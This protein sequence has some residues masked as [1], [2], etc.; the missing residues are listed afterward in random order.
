MKSGTRPWPD[1]WL[2]VA[3]AAFFTVIQFYTSLAALAPTPPVGYVFASQAAAVA[4]VAVLVL[5]VL[6]AG[7][8]L[9]RDRGPLPAPSRAILA[10]WIGSAALSSA[11][12][13]DPVSSAQVVGMMALGGVFHLALV[14]YYRRPGVAGAVL[15]SY[16]AAGLGA[17]VAALAMAATRRPPALWA[18]NHGRAAG[19]FVT[20]NQLAAFLI[21]FGFVALGVALARTGA[22]RRLAQAGVL[23]SLA[24]LAA[25]VS[26]AGWIG[27]AAGGAFLAVALGARRTALAL[28]AAATLAALAL[29]SRPALGHNPAEAFDRLR[30]WHAG[31]RVAEL[32][33][34]TGA[35]PMAYWRVY[36]A[37]RPANGDL[38]GTFGAL[39]PHDA[40]L[41]LA[42]ETGLIGLVACGYG[43]WRFGRAMRAGLRSLPRAERTFALGVCAAL[44]AVLVQGLFDTIGVVQMAFVW[45]PYTALA[46][47][48]ARPAAP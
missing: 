18:V 28:V 16:L 17:A 8:R 45:I 36:P 27:A 25:T 29:V 10:A 43:W 19:F 2:A 5:A 6:V 13:V 20:P 31:I 32:F 4:L 34:L 33:P 30:V 38:P 22:V 42:G 7:L 11:L 9:V 47:A 48:A 24:A 15:V 41:S 26:Q 35:G 21:A 12:G 1:V 3:L 39:H 46:L 23:A 44:V 14:R 37:I 40:Y